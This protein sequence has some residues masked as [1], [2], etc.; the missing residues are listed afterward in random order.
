MCINKVAIVYVKSWNLWIFYQKKETKYAQMLC[1]VHRCP[2]AWTQL[3]GSQSSSRGGTC[4]ARPDCRLL[5]K[6]VYWSIQHYP[7]LLQLMFN[8]RRMYCAVQKQ[9]QKT[10]PT[11]PQVSAVQLPHWKGSVALGCA[12]QTTGSTMLM[13]HI[14]EL[15][16]GSVS[17]ICLKKENNK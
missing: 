7:T 5:N 12:L 13:R 9:V 10:S 11:L 6:Q 8:L 1:S 15:W 17:S 16:K 2:R 3:C 4:Q 14:L